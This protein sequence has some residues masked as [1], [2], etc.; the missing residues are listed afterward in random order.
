VDCNDVEFFLAAPADV[1]AVTKPQ[2]DLDCHLATCEQCRELIAGIS[3]QPL[4]WVVGVPQDAFADRDLLALAVVD[5]VMF[6]VESELARGGMGRVT[7]ARDRRLG[8]DVAI[9]EVL[10]PKLDARFAREVAITAQLQHPAIVPVYEAGRW[11]DGSA[12]YAMRLVSGG[13]LSHA[14][15]KTRTLEDRLALL[16][17]VIALTDALAYAHANR[18]IHRDLKPGN[19]LVGEFG[20]TVVI[21]WGLAKQLDRAIGDGPDMPARPSSSDLTVVGSVMGTPGFMSPEQIAGAT[22]DERTDVYALGAILYNLLAGKAPY[23]FGET[24]VTPALI[25]KREREGPPDSLAVV[26][27]RVPVDL[28]VIVERAMARDREARYSNAKELADELRRFAAGQLLMSRHYSTRELIVRWLRRH[29]TAVAIAAVAIVGLAVLGATSVHQTV[30]RR[31]EAEHALATSRI[32][33]GRQLLIS[34]KPVLAAGLFAAALDRVDDP[35]AHRLATIAVRDADRRLATFAGTT[36]AFR[37]DGAM[38]AIGHKDGSIALVDAETG[39]TRETLPGTDAVTQLAYS[40]NGAK[41]LVAS[42]AGISLVDPATR[43]ASVLFHG[44]VEL[45]RFAGEQI[46]FSDGTNV[47]VMTGNVDRKTATANASSFDVAGD[48]L[49]ALTPTETIVWSLPELQQLISQPPATYALLDREGGFVMADNDALQRVSLADGSRVVLRVGESQPL[50]R[51]RDGS[52]ASGVELVDIAAHTTHELAPA[53]ASELVAALDATHVITGGFDKMIRI[54]RLDLARPLVVVEAANAVEE[55]IPNAAGTRVVSIGR[56][57]AIELW[58]SGHLR[59]PVLAAEL[60]APIARIV[61]GRSGTAAWLHVPGSNRVAILDASHH[62]VGLVPGWPAGYRPGGDELLVNDGGKLFVYAATTGAQLHVVA[63]AAG[64]QTAAYSSSGSVLATS[65]A[66]KITLRDALTW[67]VIGT[68]ETHRDDITTIALDDAGHVVTGHGNGTLEIW[69]S[70]THTTVG[71]LDG[72]SAHIEDMALRGSR[73]VT[74]SW[75]RT[76]RAWQLAPG[77]PQSTELPAAGHSL[78]VS[79]SGQ[80]IATVDRS[81]L[82]SVWD[83]LGGRLLEQFP[84]AGGLDAVAFSG[85]DQLVVGG[86]DGKLELIDLHERERSTAELVRLAHAMQP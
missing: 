11:P 6:E 37:P 1:D 26:A 31:R 16:P 78:A 36:A 15:A 17:H 52:I 41:L 8:R 47:H 61:A 74:T 79:P 51:L 48:R 69:D 29:R 45:A 13:T 42:R 4:Q 63:D 38:L 83:A 23:W 62:Q 66:G 50:T 80:L 14:I 82:V 75:D 44:N 55:L 71:K 46:V 40:P 68:F 54:V 77:S 65:A 67:A 20:E 43:A 64:I 72:H 70:R 7:K 57:G 73:L 59:E 27:P 39:T 5:P 49:L 58:D 19:V 25:E 30:R 33:Q 53:V 9:K 81:A 10:S 12:F 22:L 18:I 24:T 34:G 35:V 32:E 28:R 56:T 84:A 86:G 85:E 76:T 3:K 60:G 21:D 2:A